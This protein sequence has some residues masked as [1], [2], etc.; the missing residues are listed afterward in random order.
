[1]LAILIDDEFMLKSDAFLCAHRRNANDVVDLLL[2][3]FVQLPHLNTS[4]TLGT[5]HLLLAYFHMPLQS[6]QK[7]KSFV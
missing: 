4:N 6:G 1:M 3:I 5:V 7:L 2:S